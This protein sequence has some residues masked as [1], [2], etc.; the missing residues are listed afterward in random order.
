MEDSLIRINYNNKEIILIPTAHVSVASAELVK[1]TIEKEKPDSVCIELDEGRYAS[2]KNPEAWKNTNIIDVIKQKKVTMLIANLIL[3]SYQKR[4]AKKL[5]TNPGQEMVQGM[6][7]ADE[8]GA[9][10]VLADR[11]IQTTFKRIWRHMGFFEKIKLTV[12]LIFADDDEEVSEEDLSELI[13]KDNLENVIDDLGK[14]YPQIANT[15]LHE[16]DEYLAYNIKNAPGDKVVAVLGAAHTPGVKKEIFKEQDI[17]ALNVIPEKSFGSKLLPWIIPVLIVALIVYSFYTSI[18]TGMNQLKSWVIFNSLFAAGFTILS[19]GHPLSV[20]TALVVAPFTSVNPLLA[21]GWFAG[22]VEATVR[23]P[24][25][26]DV[27]NIPEDIF[28]LKSWFKNKFLKALL[29]VIMANIGS[30]IGTLI[31]GTKIIQNLL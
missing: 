30:S 20:L 3:S 17:D 14:S 22:L 16:R 19:L 11:D 2:L 15:L 24:T 6:K 25:V 7:S 13:Q 18:N 27:N 10:L 31:A 4:V 5:K 21:C 26:E 23:K 8:V 12:S 9:E 1:E 28:K 29:V